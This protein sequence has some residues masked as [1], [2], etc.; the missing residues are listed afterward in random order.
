MSEEKPSFEER[1]ARL[2]EIVSKIEGETLPLEQAMAF[3]Q[4]GRQLI[5]G[6]QKDLSE[7]EAK[8]EESLKGTTED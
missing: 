2:N 3:F 1:L 5:E 6:L 8:V 4:E 7:A